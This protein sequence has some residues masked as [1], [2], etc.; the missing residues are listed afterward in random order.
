MQHIR[1]QRS[2]GRSVNRLNLRI[3]GRTSA[4]KI[5]TPNRL[6]LQS[7]REI[8]FDHSRLEALSRDFEADLLERPA[9]VE[10]IGENFI[11]EH[12][13]EDI[14]TQE[15]E[16]WPLTALDFQTQD[17]SEHTDKAI[18]SW[19]LDVLS[20]SDTAHAMIEEAQDYGWNFGLADL[21][22]HDFHLDAIDKKLLIHNHNL[23][24]AAIARSGY[25]INAVMVA[26]MRG[27][28]DIWQEK[29]HGG[30][31]DHYGI[32]DVLMLE[33]VRAADLDVLSIMTAWEMRDQGHPEI[34]RHVLASDIGD[35]AMVYGQAVEQRP[36]SDIRGNAAT[37]A[38]R[39]WYDSA[40]RVNNCDHETLDYL[41][42]LS[43]QANGDEYHGDRKPTE[44]GVEILSCMPDKTAYLK[45]WGNDIMCDPYFTGLQDPINQAHFMQLV[46]EREIVYCE[47]VGFRD[48][49]LAARI[50]PTL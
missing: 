24:A 44:I 22:T 15:A 19:C 27:L 14:D 41:D 23:N 4:S 20:L 34:W 2:R 5:A 38:F 31:E 47:G 40:V 8:E 9:L 36:F 6:N 46:N 39:K 45:G 17:A 43:R 21:D 16:S 18:L 26:M 13:I 50:F 32:E 28:R 35:M 33:R 29:R 1:V 11:P 30:F 25:F 49:D 48:T 42:D 12:Y 10:P 3:Q 7:I 37:A